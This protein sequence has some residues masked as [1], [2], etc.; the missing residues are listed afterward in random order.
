[1]IIIWGIRSRRTEIGKG[2]FDCPK[3]GALRDYRHIQVADYFTLFFLPL[4][5]V[6]KRGAY[7]ECLVCMHTFKPEARTGG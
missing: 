5:R 6:R 7:V 1:M 3:C 2:Q 4:F